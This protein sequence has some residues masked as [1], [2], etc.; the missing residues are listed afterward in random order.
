MA[1][2]LAFGSDAY[3]ATGT[4]TATI[5]T[6]ISISQNTGSQTS[7]TN[8]ELAFG[9][10]IPGPGGTV[11]VPTSGTTTASGVTL[12]TQLPT[13]PAE[14]KVTG[15]TGKSYT[16]TLPSTTATIT[17]AGGGATMTVTGL[18]S[19]STGSLA[20]GEEIF[21]VGGVLTIA[22]GQAAGVYSGT[23]TVNAAYN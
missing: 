4:A 18:S 6:A 15:D 12:T 14:F 19:D 21:H 23:F 8:A 2:V 7:S 20:G 13:G 1:A 11:T 16:A 3:A 5:G 17:K 9:H 22:A 10:I